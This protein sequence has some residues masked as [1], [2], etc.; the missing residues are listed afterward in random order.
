MVMK[1]HKRPK[2]LHSHLVFYYFKKQHNTTGNS[3]SPLQCGKRSIFFKISFSLCF[4][5]VCHCIVTHSVWALFK[6]HTN[7]PPPSLKIFWVTRSEFECEKYM[8]C[9]WASLIKSSPEKRLYCVR[10]G[11]SDTWSDE[12]IHCTDECFQ[13]S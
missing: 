11:R 8:L 1:I 4:F 12:L 3:C 9:F 7:Q 10:V 6:E 2:F 13:L 5:S